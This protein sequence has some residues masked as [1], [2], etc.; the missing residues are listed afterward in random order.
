VFS[1]AR[2]REQG[3][4]KVGGRRSR[5]PRSEE[6]LKRNRRTKEEKKTK[7]KKQKKKKKQDKNIFYILFLQLGLRYIL[8]PDGLYTEQGALEYV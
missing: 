3:T 5:K 2:L 1:T 6:G 4:E 7:K 8:P